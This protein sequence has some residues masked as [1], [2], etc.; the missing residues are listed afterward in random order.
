MT[1]QGATSGEQAKVVER[2]VD[3]DRLI[4][5]LERGREMLSGAD[6]RPLF[7]AWAACVGDEDARSRLP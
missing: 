5:A 4:A 3:F 1:A 2:W 7:L 6:L